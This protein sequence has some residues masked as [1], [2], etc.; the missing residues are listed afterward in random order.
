ML[1][2]L[3]YFKGWSLILAPNIRARKVFILCSGVHKMLTYEVAA[4]FETEQRTW[5]LLALSSQVCEE[6]CNWTDII[7]G[8]TKEYRNP[9]FKCISL[10]GL[11]WH[12]EK[13]GVGW[14]VYSYVIH[15]CV[16]FRDVAMRQSLPHLNREAEHTRWK[17]ANLVAGWKRTSAVLVRRSAEILKWLPL[18]CSAHWRVWLSFAFQL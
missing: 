16:Y 11:Y 13:S 18:R 17:D 7:V 1:N 2:A 9:H 10:W 14:V 12:S 15:C 8:C 5:T 6:C 3:S 4:V